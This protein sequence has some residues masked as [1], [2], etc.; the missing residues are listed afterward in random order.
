MLFT[1]NS[2]ADRKSFYI[3]F[4]DYDI[5]LY[6]N[7]TTALVFGEMERFFIL[8]GDHRKAYTELKDFN[9]CFEYFKNNIKFINKFSEKP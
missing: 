9:A 1:P 7:N 2:I 8:N 3:S 5:E 6:G 4:N